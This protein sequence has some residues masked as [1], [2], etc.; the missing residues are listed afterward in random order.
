MKSI[1]SPSTARRKPILRVVATTLVLSSA[2][3]IT[4]A[5]ADNLSL[6]LAVPGLS[7][8]VGGAPA[9]YPVSPPVVYVPPP[10]PV[11]YYA[12]PPP[13]P[14][15]PPPGPPPPGPGPWGGPPP[16]P[17]PGPPPSYYAA[18]TPVVGYV[19]TLW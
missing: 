14:P 13:P 17:P 19:S 7:V 8:S 18:P 11:Y 16:P 5:L 4:P 1:P 6:G 10:Q 12:A 3:G 9:Y 2:V 15:P